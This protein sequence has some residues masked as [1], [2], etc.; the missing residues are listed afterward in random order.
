MSKVIWPRRQADPLLTRDD[1]DAVFKWMFDVR[2][3]VAAIRHT[4][5]NGDGEED[6]EADS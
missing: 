3:E 1:I 6:P 5:E 2:F 4:L